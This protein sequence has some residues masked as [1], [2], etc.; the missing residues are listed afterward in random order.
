[1]LIPAK[2]RAGHGFW[3]GVFFGQR[4]Y[5]WLPSL[6]GTKKK[7]RGF[8]MLKN[9]VRSVVLGFLDL[10]RQFGIERA[11]NRFSFPSN[12]FV[13]TVQPFVFSCAGLVFASRRA[14]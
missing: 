12:P 11:N 1:M 9:Y 5:F 7:A 10:A 4:D 13:Q 3:R 14:Q 8:G 2:S 6:D